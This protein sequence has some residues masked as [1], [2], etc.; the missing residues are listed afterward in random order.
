MSPKGDKG[1]VKP[2]RYHSRSVQ[3]TA[4]VRPVT[5]TPGGAYWQTAF[6]PRLAGDI[7]RVRPAAL[8][9]NAGGSLRDSVPVTRPVHSR[10]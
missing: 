6:G 8:P 9:P 4:L 5:G 7:H 3:C 2:L 10:S 1:V